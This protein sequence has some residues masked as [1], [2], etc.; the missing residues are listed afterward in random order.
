MT[1]APDTAAGLFRAGR[2]ADAVSA[3][4]AALK[5]A[6]TDL[7][8]RVFLAELLLFTNEFERADTLLDAG[9]DLSPDT[10]VVIAEFRQLLRAELSRRQLY[11]DGRVPDFLGSPS[12]SLGNALAA[13]VAWRAGDWE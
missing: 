11:R 10:T 9:A 12:P 1:D 3:A 8:A 4:G 2:L 5:R 13:L 6:P 7:N